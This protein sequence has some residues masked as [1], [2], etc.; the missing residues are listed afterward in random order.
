MRSQKEEE[1]KS[2]QSCTWIAALVVVLLFALAYF[3]IYSDRKA[4]RGSMKGGKW[5]AR[6]GCACVPPP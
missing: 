2:N 6:G 5:V 1:K 3:A 4:G